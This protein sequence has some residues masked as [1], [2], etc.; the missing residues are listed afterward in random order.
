M[1]KKLASDFFLNNFQFEIFFY[2][3]KLDANNCKTRRV[4]KFGKK[5]YNIKGEVQAFRLK[6]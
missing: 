2:E 3:N 5:Q 6:N 4:L 1:C